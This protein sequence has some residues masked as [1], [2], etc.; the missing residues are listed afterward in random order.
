MRCVTVSAHRYLAWHTKTGY[1]NGMA[2]AVARSGHI[3][4]EFLCCG[5]QI[6]VVVRRLIIYI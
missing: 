1:M 6:N 4:A 2:D 3:H 5:L